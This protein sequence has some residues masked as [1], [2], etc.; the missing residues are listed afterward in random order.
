MNLN[1]NDIVG[2]KEPAKTDLVFANAG[3]LS[4]K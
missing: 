4:I 2:E 1:K 3:K